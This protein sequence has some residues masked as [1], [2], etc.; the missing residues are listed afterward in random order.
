M[1]TIHL[2]ISTITLT[3]LLTDL[4]NYYYKCH[5]NFNLD[6]SRKLI[7]KQFDAAQP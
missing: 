4:I 1:P 5:D 6:R 7:A 2:L 3:D